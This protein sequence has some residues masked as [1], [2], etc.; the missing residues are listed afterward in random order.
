M[1]SGVKATA[2][3]ARGALALERRARE[4]T[5]R[6]PQDMKGF[7]GL[8]RSGLGLDFT[9]WPSSQLLLSSRWRQQ[10]KEISGADF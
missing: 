2:A 9:L 5:L 3:R 1:P 10:S 4:G 7:G 8:G 6:S